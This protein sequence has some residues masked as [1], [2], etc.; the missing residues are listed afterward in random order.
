MKHLK[1]GP[2]SPE[3]PDR[4][5]AF[6]ELVTL[7]PHQGGFMRSAITTEQLGSRVPKGT[8][9]GEVVSLYT[10]EILERVEDPFESSILILGRESVT[11]VDPGDYGYMIANAAS[12]REV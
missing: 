10:F 6:T 12:A 2:G 3:I 4:Q 7:R 9:L 11:K 5:W 8:L 1:M